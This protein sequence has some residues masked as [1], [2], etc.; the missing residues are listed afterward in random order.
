[1]LFRQTVA[2]LAGMAP[3][4]VFSWS[5]RLLHTI[6]LHVSAAPACAGASFFSLSEQ[7]LLCLDFSFPSSL[8]TQPTMTPCHALLTASIIECC[9]DS[10]CNKFADVVGFTQ[11]AGCEGQGQQLPELQQH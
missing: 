8:F 11:A 6:L 10:G 5:T 9:P 2:L 4:C 1:V 3:T 7:A